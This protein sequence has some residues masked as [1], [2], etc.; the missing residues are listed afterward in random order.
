LRDRIAAER[1][2][3]GGLA[4]R[5]YSK[6]L[7]EYE[8]LAV[9]LDFAEKSYLAALAAE[10]VA[11]TEARRQGRHLAVYDPPLTPQSAVEPRRA[12]LFFSVLAAAMMLWAVLTLAGYGLRDRM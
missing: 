12:I 3:F 2:K 10:E 4:E 9:E 8:S 11:R 6:L 5:D 7:A 1:E